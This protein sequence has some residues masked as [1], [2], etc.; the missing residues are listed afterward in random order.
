MTNLMR[1]IIRDFKVENYLGMT[2]TR[3]ESELLGLYFPP[4][5]LVDGVFDGIV[6]TIG[7]KVENINDLSD[8]NKFKIKVYDSDFSY[9]TLTCSFNIDMFEINE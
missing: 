4:F 3:V 2:I 5:I 9:D 8:K 7:K 1:Y 6:F